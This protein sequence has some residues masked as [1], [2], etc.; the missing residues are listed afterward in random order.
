MQVTD[1]PDGR[2]D[3]L[4]MHELLRRLALTARPMKFSERCVGTPQLGRIL[5]RLRDGERLPQ[6]LLRLRG[7]A[8]GES[9]LPAQAPALHEVA[10]RLGSASDLQTFVRE[11]ACGIAVAAREGQLAEAGEEM[12]RV[13]P[14][15]P[16][17][18][19]RPPNEFMDAVE[20][21]LRQSQIALGQIGIPQIKFGVGDC[22]GV[23]SLARGFGAPPIE[24][25]C[26]IEVPTLQVHPAERVQDAMPH[27]LFT[28]LL[29]DGQTLLQDGDAFVVPT[30]A[31]Q[32]EA[33]PPQIQEEWEHDPMLT[34]SR[35]RD[36][37]SAPRFSV[38]ALPVQQGTGQALGHDEGG[39]I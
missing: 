9:D 18:R 10:L 26:D 25:D 28:R 11:A 15:H 35:D 38:I 37:L 20:E 12:R 16:L 33:V 6:R 31:G 29:T 27:D 36:L 4:L 24:L 30:P 21:L 7:I 17:A 19:G 3:G 8:P 5:Y 23:T 32:R 1:L 34:R 22:L 13:P 39:N 2:E 14:F